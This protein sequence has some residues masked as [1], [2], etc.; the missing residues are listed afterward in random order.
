MKRKSFY[1]TL[2]IVIV[3]NISL[4]ATEASEFQN[5]SS[6]HS[7][8]CDKENG[9]VL[10]DSLCGVN[11]SIIAD[12]T[13][14][15][16][17]NA[18]SEVPYRIP[19][20]AETRNGDLI[21]VADYRYS[22]ADIGMAKNG[23]LDL[24]Y[25]IKDGKTGEWGEV[26]TLVSAFGE[27]ENNIAFGD[28]CIVAD[29]ESDKILVTSCSG[30]VS[31]PKGTHDNHQGWA[32]FYSEDGGKTWSGY[33]EIGNQVFD[34]LDN[35]ADG[36]I[37][38]FFIGSGKISQSNKVK[39]DDFYRIYCA[40]LVR[41]ND[42]KTKVNY[43]FYSDDFGKNWKLLGDV[44]DCPIPF[45]ADE[46][47]VEELP[48]GNILISSRVSG[49]RAFNIFYFDNIEEGKGR[50][51]KMETSNAS[52]NG[53]AASS[54]ACN[55]E[56]LCV[57][58]VRN[59][60]GKTGWLLLQSVPLNT[61]GLR[62]NVGI[63]Y[64]DISNLNDCYTPSAIS[65]DWNGKYEVT[66]KDSAYSTMVLNKNGELAFLYE[67]NSFN[68]GYDIVYKTISIDTLTDGKYSFLS[69]PTSDNK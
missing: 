33:E 35:R 8:C 4:F 5:L 55:G 60:D 26:K 20:I 63:N 18:T 13:F 37:N 66:P 38:A 48:D 45:G 40:A 11:D 1:I 14:I 15:V 2:T 19:A 41:I 68:G 43:V 31:F 27:D 32:R 49:G 61:N 54:N 69:F 64:K 58:V 36:P 16:F 59:S 22:K 62:A 65:A 12:E 30:N 17:D 3:S 50:W 6:S 46:P 44:D 9:K 25:R 47:K 34:I 42:G 53:V 57:P 39:V 7:I 24:R 10:K 21:A 67:E 52:V 23:K 56:T 29:R 28:P 51:G